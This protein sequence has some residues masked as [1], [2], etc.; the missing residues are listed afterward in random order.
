MKVVG[1]VQVST[2]DVKAISAEKVKEVL[3]KIGSRQAVRP[4]QVPIEMWK[5][6]GAQG[7]DLFTNLFNV[8]LRVG[9][10]PKDTE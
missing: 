7:V 8:I 9:K 4:V 3:R 6:L 10:M 1:E 5:S 2:G